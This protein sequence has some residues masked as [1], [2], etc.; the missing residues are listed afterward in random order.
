M[1]AAGDVPGVVVPPELAGLV[2]VLLGY[3]L[4]HLASRNGG[5]PE[6]AGL[7]GLRAQL[8]VTATAAS[9]HGRRTL[10]VPEPPSTFREVTVREAAE[11]SGLSTRQV[12]RLAESG[13]LIARK[14]GRDWHIDSDSASGYGRR[15]A[16]QGPRVA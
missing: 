10:A 11:V 15:R 12:R 16:W 14:R 2:D 9:G 1:T 3:G 4:G 6:V 7:N 5:L 13:A 8:R